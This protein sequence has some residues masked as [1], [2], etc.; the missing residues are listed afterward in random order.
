MAGPCR[1]ALSID[2]CVRCAAGAADAEPDPVAV[3]YVTR[4]EP[5]SVPTY[6]VGGY[7]EPAAGA[8][9]GRPPSRPP[10]PSS[11]PWRA[12][13]A[14]ARLLALCSAAQHRR[15]GAR[16]ASVLLAAGKGSG[17][18]LDALKASTS[19]IHYLG[20]AG[21][22]RRR[23][24]WLP[25]GCAAAGAAAA[26]IRGG[27]LQ[28]LRPA[29]CTLHPALCHW[30]ESGLAAS[31]AASVAATAWRQAQHRPSTRCAPLL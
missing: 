3:E 6:F 15:R 14:T 17:L 11:R 31:L 18:L 23:R 25:A 10:C 19:G 24:C 1:A 22:V 28:L 9:P 5:V 20:R 7:G 29:S 27:G 21:V 13:Q 30:H 16:P 2:C 12:R 26:C 8:P 4:S